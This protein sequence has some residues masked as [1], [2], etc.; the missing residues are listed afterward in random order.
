[1]DKDVSLFD[2]AISRLRNQATGEKS[3]NARTIH[4]DSRAAA[5]PLPFPVPSRHVTLDLEAMRADGYLPEAKTAQQ[6]ANHYRRIKRPLIDKAVSGP[7]SSSLD[8]RVIMVT[9]ALPGDGKT[10]TSI[11]LAMSMALERD[12]SVLLVDCDVAKRHVSQIVGMQDEPGLVDAL[13]DE[14]IEIE[15]L[16]AATN[17][18]GLSILPAG[19]R[20]EG[21]PELLS[22][23]RMRFLVA[24]LCS[25]VPRRLLLL[26]SPPL[27]ITDEGRA[28][29][30]IAGQIALVVRAEHTPRQAV[31]D[32]MG[33]FS[34]EQAGG[35]ILNDVSRTRADKYHSYGYGTDNN[36]T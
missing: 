1:L 5:V 2:Q 11:N 30:K 18:R 14:T 16:V 17:L 25:R 35:I 13:I 32:A 6:F 22:S 31:I 15:S 7:G 29:T 23:I 24:A 27:L 19:Q 33:L 10:F 34:L 26:D 8:P 21:T 9:S 36:A 12:M 3:Q 20:V 28:L 4:S